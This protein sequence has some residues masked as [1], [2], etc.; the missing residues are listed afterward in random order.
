VLYFALFAI[1]GVKLAGAKDGF[2]LKFEYR[3]VGL[4]SG[5]V[6]VI[7]LIKLITKFECEVSS[8]IPLILWFNWLWML[9]FSIVYPLAI[10]MRDRRFSFLRCFEGYTKE[11]R[12]SAKCVAALGSA[13]SREARES[14]FETR[15]YNADTLTK[16]RE[17]PL[18]RFLTSTP[19]REAF[20]AFIVC[21]FSVENLLFVEAVQALNDREHLSREEANALFDQYVATSAPSQVNIPHLVA[22]KLEEHLKTDEVLDRTMFNEAAGHVMKLMHRDAYRRFQKT[23]QWAALVAVFSDGPEPAH[24]SI[25]PATAPPTPRTSV[26]GAEEMGAEAAAAEDATASVEVCV[27]VP[28]EVQP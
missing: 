7:Y 19:A 16:L 9:S 1:F 3:M 15:T 25:A 22:Q 11:A 20:R 6:C 2:H 8:C 26:V 28:T 14:A 27:E 5:S 4:G 17:V 24:P 23:P 21:E 18:G 12:K 10:A 13:Q